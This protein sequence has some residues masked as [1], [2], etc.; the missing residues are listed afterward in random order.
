[1]YWAPCNACNSVALIESWSYDWLLKEYYKSSHNR[2]PE[3]GKRYGPYSSSTEIFC[4]R[5]GAYF[6]RRV[7]NLISER[8]A[9]LLNLFF[10]STRYII[11]FFSRPELAARWTVDAWNKSERNGNES[12]L[13]SRLRD[14]T[15]H[16]EGSC[17]LGEWLHMTMEHGAH[18][19]SLNIA[20]DCSLKVS[21]RCR[22]SQI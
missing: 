4:E 7:Q 6:E 14:D 12:Q 5:C 8:A 1:M 13:Y 16:L 11:T 22:Y 18:W 19:K 20:K 9:R 15:T 21:G 17:M 3:M 10:L 2:P